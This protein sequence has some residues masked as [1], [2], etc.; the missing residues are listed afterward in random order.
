MSMYIC[1][2]K[3]SPRHAEGHSG[4]CCHAYIYIYT[5][6]HTYICMYM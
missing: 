1:R 2:F 6:T 3:T 5:Y 4:L